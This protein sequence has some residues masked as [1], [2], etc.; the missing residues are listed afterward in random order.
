MEFYIRNFCLVI[1]LL[2]SLSFC[3]WGSNS[4]LI[5]GPFYLPGS[6]EDT[7]EPNPPIEGGSGIYLIDSIGNKYPSGS[8]YSF[9]N[10]SE[11]SQSANIHFTIAGEY[12][13]PEYVHLLG[14]PSIEFTGPYAY[15][16]GIQGTVPNQFTKISQN[17]TAGFD[18]Y[19]FADSIGAKNAKLV[20]PVDDP[21]FGSYY[22]NLVGAGTNVPAPRFQLVE[23]SVKY[24]AYSA[25]IYSSP[26]N[27]ESRTYTIRNT[28]EQDLIISNI[29][30]GTQTSIFSVSETQ[31]TIAP[32]KSKNITFTFSPTQLGT[33]QTYANFH[34]NDP[35]ANLYSIGVFGYSFAS[36]NAPIIEIS[37]SGD[38]GMNLANTSNID[39]GGI[40]PGQSSST[41]TVI[42]KNLGNTNLDLTQTSVYLVGFD[43]SDF[44]LVKSTLTSLAPGK[45]TT[46]GIRFVPKSA[47]IKTATL[48]IESPNG[49]KGE[50]YNG[51]I[52]LQGSGGKKDA[53]I[54][55]SNSKNSEVN[56]IN[57]SYKVCYKKGSSFNSE[58]ETG[59]KCDDVANSSG[60]AFTPTFKKIGTLS[61]G[62]WYLR[63]KSVV[64]REPYG[65]WKSEFSEPKKFVVQ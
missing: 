16:F 47:G 23:A 34:T 4:K 10:I 3:R 48:K 41:Q 58:E 14:N 52:G 36:A 17:Q 6:S 32:G 24:D 42:L 64:Y 56:W 54:T 49:L 9:G 7:E 60:L 29:E 61:K 51:Y 31:F 8:I 44:T 13:D 21:E 30:I 65:N 22:L 59:V 11:L 35:N 62:T 39:F 46:Y 55:W 25:E 33:Q 19:F 2:L 45:A 15:G 5:S 50:Q 1:I 12:P 37:Y 40:E 63:I 38:Y 18:I 43:I 20:I 28:G 57:G 53:Y 27:T 26:G